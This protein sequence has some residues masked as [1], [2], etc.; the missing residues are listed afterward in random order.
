MMLTSSHRSQARPKRFL[1]HESKVFFAALASGLPGVVVALV[2]LWI[3]R[4]GLNVQ[5]TLT[6]V[7]VAGWVSFAAAAR[8]VVLYKLRTLSN[9]LHTVAEGDYTLRMS[10]GS[11]KGVLG[12]VAREANML[13][14]TLHERRVDAVE[15]SALLRQVMAEID[16]AVIAFDPDERLSLLN[17]QAEH[18]FGRPAS[19]VLGKS[20]RELRVSDLLHGEVPRIVELV[21]LGRAGRWELRRASFRE[22]S[23]QHQLVVLSDL[24][25]TLHE[26]ERSAWRRLVQ[27]LQHEINNSLAPISS[28]AEMLG[29]LVTS[30]PRPEDWQE[31]LTK[32]LGV[33]A[34]RSEALNRF[35]LSYA[36]LTRIPKPTRG[37][38]K[39]SDWVERVVSL[40]RR[41]PVRIVSGPDVVIQADSDQLDQLLINIVRNA[42]DAVSGAPGHI[43]VGWGINGQALDVWVED[44]GPGLPD[45]DKLFTPFYSTKPKGAGI[46][47]LMCRQIAETHEGTIHLENLKER[48]GCRAMVCLPLSWPRMGTEV[49]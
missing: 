14:E 6:C 39:V 20:A 48:R 10:E 25:R 11:D 13:G 43:T 27:I 9:F 8:A 15:A 16:V 30:E 37:P 44:D 21:T 32:G 34:H 40:E 28:L 23:L 24:T 29:K 17:P 18:L 12:E 31:D 41:V 4:Y 49:S 5:L 35:M 26:E 7:I 46:G 22:K 33:I 36:R 19:H 38:L 3:G 1:S 47:L 42:A 2:F 45:T